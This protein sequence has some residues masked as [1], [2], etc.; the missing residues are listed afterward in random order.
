MAWWGKKNNQPARRQPRYMTGQDNTSFRRSRT[1]SDR[2]PTE[3][4][5]EQSA[6]LQ[7][8]ARARRRHI[9]KVVTIVTIIGSILFYWLLTQYALTVGFVSFTPSPT[10]PPQEQRYKDAISDYLYKYP[11]ERFRFILNEK[12]FSEYLG[13]KLPEVSAAKSSGGGIG[14]GDYTVTLREPLV[15]WQVGERQYL[16][17]KNGVP[18]DQNYFN[19]PSVNVV[20]QSGVKIEDGGV[21]ASNRFLSFL[22]RIVSLVNES[23]IGQVEKIVIPAGVTRQVDVYLKGSAYP[24]KTNVDRDP[25]QQVE[26][27]KKVLDFLK[28]RGI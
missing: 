27:M 8:H 4:Q 17:D 20:D 25:A 15:G 1:L 11:A 28:Q 10:K 26:D 14:Y 7:E 23:G 9:V 19:A 5:K 24:I 13:D 6:R 2:A 16:V 18:F 22:G 21:I 3:Q 12:R